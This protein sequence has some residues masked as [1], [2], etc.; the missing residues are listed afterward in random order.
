MSSDEYLGF[1]ETAPSFS[2]APNMEIIKI[3][4]SRSTVLQLE[5]SKNN[6]YD[7]ERDALVL[8]TM[9]ATTFD[10][11]TWEAFV[12]LIAQRYVLPG[13]MEEA[14]KLMR[15]KQINIVPV[16]PKAPRPRK[17][18]NDDSDQDAE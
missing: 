4:G 16:E 17:K 2:I 1:E 7:P 15:G 10:K 6:E 3:F 11:T 14:E 18:K 13:M 5:I 12:N 9:L 8:E